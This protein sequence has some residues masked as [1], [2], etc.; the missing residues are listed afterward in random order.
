MIFSRVND[1]KMTYFLR[2]GILIFIGINEQEI[3]LRKLLR[4]QL[5]TNIQGTIFFIFSKSNKPEHNFQPVPIEKKTIKFVQI[6]VESGS[7]G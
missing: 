6:F 1:I 4:R 2:A 3:I 5:Y 7:I